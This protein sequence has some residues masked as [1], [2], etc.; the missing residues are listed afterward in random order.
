MAFTLGFES[1]TAQSTVESDGRVVS[2]YTQ[3]MLY[4]TDAMTRP[5]QYAIASD[6]GIIPGS[7]F[8]QDLNATCYDMQ[9][10]PVEKKTKPPY[11][12]YL[13]AFQWATNAPLPITNNTDP[14]TRRTLWAIRPNIQ[15]RYLVK[16]LTGQL[17]VNT[18]NQP[19]DGGYPVDVRLGTVIAT[20]NVDAAGYNRDAVLAISGRTNSVIF[21]GGAIGTVQGDVETVEKFEGAFHFWEETWTFTWDPLGLP[22]QLPS[23]GFFQRDSYDHDKLKRITSRDLDPDATNDDPVEEPEPLDASG[24]LVPVSARPGGVAFI[25]PNVILTFNFNTLGL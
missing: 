12:S 16:D 10:G 8:S 17:I 25:R 7:P 6:I 18:A 22:S 2:K 14:T 4:K 5:T 15:Q 20:R 9:I 21:L 3:V 13:V 1:E 24:L 11:L 23:V 19:Y